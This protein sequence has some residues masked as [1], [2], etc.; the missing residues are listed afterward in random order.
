MC[1]TLLFQIVFFEQERA[2]DKRD[3]L[4]LQDFPILDDLNIP[5]NEES[6]L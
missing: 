2:G 4:Y 5:G 1:A 3:P 6:K